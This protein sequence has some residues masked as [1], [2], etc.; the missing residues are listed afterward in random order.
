MLDPK[1]PLLE[2]RQALHHLELKAEQYRIHIGELADGHEIERARKV[3]DKMQ[4]EIDVQQR[5]CDL[6][7]KAE[8]ASGVETNSGSSHAA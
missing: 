5:S 7:A 6:L 3:L 2:A 1:T 8:R 4:A